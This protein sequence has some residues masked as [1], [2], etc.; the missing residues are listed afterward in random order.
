[1]PELSTVV[2]WSPWSRTGGSVTARRDQQ[3]RSDHTKPC[4]VVRLAMVTIHISISIDTNSDQDSATV[5]GE[6]LKDLVW[7]EVYDNMQ[8]PASVATA[9]AEIS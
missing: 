5:L 8:L 4:P 1:V 7:N 6:R 9:Y 3:E 2:V